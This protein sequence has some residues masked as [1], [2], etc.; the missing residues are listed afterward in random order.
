MALGKSS[1]L[2]PIAPARHVALPGIILTLALLMLMAAGCASG[3]ETLTTVTTRP[4]APPPPER[5]TIDYFQGITEPRSTDLDTLLAAAGQLRD[6]GFNA[7]TL[8]PTVLIDQRVGGKLRVI[9][10]GSAM[11]VRDLA[12]KFRG[13]GMAVLLAPTT[14]SPGFEETI[15]IE[16]TILEHLTEDTLKW[17]DAAEV[18]NVEMFAPLSRCNLALGTDACHG[19]LQE[20]LPQ[21][22]ERYHGLLAAKVVADIEDQPLNGGPHD[23]ESL[24][25][26]G[27]DYLVVDVH[28]WGHIYEAERFRAYAIDVIDR[29]QA[30]AA[31]DGL[32]GVIIG[33][34]R[35]GRIREEAGWMQTGTWLNEEQQAE[36]ADMVLDIAAERTNGIFFYGWSLATYGARDYP[37]EDI[38]VKHFSGGNSEPEAPGE[39]GTT[40][41]S[42]STTGGDTTATTIVNNG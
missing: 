23:F 17:A 30:I 28:P 41:D 12:G 16:D 20:V 42:N 32:K 1:I 29:A 24:D 13:E 37:V 22:K 36:A 10:D 27:Y 4:E 8:E 5:Q 26:T 6:D 33:D 2:S 14:A 11:T 38:L 25:Y 31:R 3:G 40:T 9:L 19:W 7:V 39:P 21:V 34:L 15:S 35:L 18:N